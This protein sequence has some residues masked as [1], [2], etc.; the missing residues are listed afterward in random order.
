MG[1]TLVAGVNGYKIEPNADL[2]GADLE[3]A[4]MPDG[5]G[6]RIANAA[7]I[8]TLNRVSTER[9]HAYIYAVDVVSMCGFM[10]VG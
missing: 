7:R 1:Q 4:T 10:F 8:R 2:T 3:G 6:T 9:P 5:P